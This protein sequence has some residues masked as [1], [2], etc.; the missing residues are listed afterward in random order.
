M[1]IAAGSLSIHT[2]LKR[3]W[4]RM[5]RGRSVD[6]C[7]MRNYAPLQM[8]KAEAACLHWSLQGNELHPS[9]GALSS[10]G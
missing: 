5:R 9:L 7:A 8:R 10:S 6:D 4:W 3:L 2:A 1:E